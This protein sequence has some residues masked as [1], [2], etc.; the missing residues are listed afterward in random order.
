MWK[1]Q[2][3]LVSGLGLRVDVDVQSGTAAP[4]FRRYRRSALPEDKGKSIPK[5]LDP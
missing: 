2:L 5:A 4:E 3:G 1:A